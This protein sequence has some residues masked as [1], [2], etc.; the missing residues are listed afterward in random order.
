MDFSIIINTHNQSKYL[1][2]CIKTCLNQN[3]S[4]YEIIIVD[5]SKR[6]SKNTYKNTKKLKYFHIKEKF[7]KFPVLNQMHQIQYGFSKSKG[8]YICLLDGDDKFSNLKLNNLSKIFGQTKNKIVQD[9]PYLFSNTFKKKSKIKFY[10]NNIFFKKILVSWPQIFGTS[11]I[12]C[13]REILDK[14]F[15]K[16]K[17]F[18][19][20]YLAIDIKL[21]LF[22]HTQFDLIALKKGLTMKRIHGNNLDKTFSNLIST[23]F[24]KRRKMQIEY[25]FFLKKKNDFNIDYI[26]TKIINLIL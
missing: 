1:D 3:Y 20:N 10:K 11:T 15:K 13:S 17:P 6:P 2:E 12:S 21:I 18:C 19:W 5:T 7:K 23:S 25:N 22:A 4:S 16:G 8:K 9:V 24:W 14:F 26:F